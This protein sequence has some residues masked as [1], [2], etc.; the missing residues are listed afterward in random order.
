MP[1]FVNESYLYTESG[2][3]FTQICIN[4]TGN[5]AKCPKVGHTYCI[6]M[7]S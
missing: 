5:S 2:S 7:E 1:H 4:K 3:V 6:S